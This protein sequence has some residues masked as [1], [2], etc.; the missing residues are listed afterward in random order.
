MDNNESFYLKVGIVSS[1]SS[2]FVMAEHEMYWY[3]VRTSRTRESLCA[4]SCRTMTSYTPWMRSANFSLNMLLQLIYDG[5]IVMLASLAIAQYLSHTSVRS[6]MSTCDAKCSSSWESNNN[7]MS[8]LFACDL[9]ILSMCKF[10]MAATEMFTIHCGEV[11]YTSQSSSRN[12]KVLG[13]W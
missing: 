13:C 8:F 6:R 3:L 11:I 10:D 7:E 1:E 2:S 9:I 5:G 12:L 4:R